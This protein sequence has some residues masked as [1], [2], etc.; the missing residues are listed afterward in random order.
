[1]N[2]KTLKLTV[3]FAVASTISNEF[4]CE[5]GQPQPVSGVLKFFGQPQ[6]GEYVVPA[7]KVLLL[8]CLSLQKG[9]LSNS[10]KLTANVGGGMIVFDENSSTMT[11]PRPLKLTS[12]ERLIPPFGGNISYWGA[13][14]DTADLYVGIP[15]QIN[16]V[17]VSNDVVIAK[18]NFKT[19]QPALVRIEKSQDLKTW[20]N[21]SNA[22]VPFKGNQTN[23]AFTTTVGAQTKAFYRTKLFPR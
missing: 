11:F 16:S 7:G 3:L 9:P 6:N 15:S 8:D 13:L 21:D 1:M 18:V 5:A 2:C 19:T 20:L 4:V 10:Q 23:L 22:I 12:G 17:G 14:V